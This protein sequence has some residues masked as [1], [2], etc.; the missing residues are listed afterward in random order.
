MW[1]FRRQE[2]LGSAYARNEESLKGNKDTIETT[3]N[4]QKEETDIFGA[5]NKE[6][7]A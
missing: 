7:D 4:N 3:A 5:Y 1:Y 2:Y 6:K